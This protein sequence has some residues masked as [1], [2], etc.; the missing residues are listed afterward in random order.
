MSKRKPR[1]LAKSRPASVSD[2]RGQAKHKSAHWYENEKSIDV[3]IWVETKLGNVCA[4]ARIRR[5]HLVEYVNRT[6]PRKP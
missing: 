2:K 3:Y 5:A 1:I 6:K 4:T